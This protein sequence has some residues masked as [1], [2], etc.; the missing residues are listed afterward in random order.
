MAPVSSFGLIAFRIKN[1]TF[2]QIDKL[3]TDNK[4]LTGL[5]SQE[6]QFLLIQRKD[7]IGY[8][9]L[10]RGKYSQDDLV[11]IKAQ[12]AGMTETERQRILDLPFEK[13]W[14]EMWGSCSSN[15]KQYTSEF[16]ASKRKIQGLRDS[17]VLRTL[18]EEAG[19]AVYKTPEWGFPKG[20]R[21]QREDNLT[22][23][24]REFNEETGLRPYHYVVLENMDPIRETFF[25]NNHVH[26]THVY[27]MAMCSS[28]LEVSMKRF[29]THMIR[30]VG[31]IQWASLEEALALIRPDN[32][33]K[34]GILLR[35]STILRNYC[36]LQM[37]VFG[38][39][40]SG[41]A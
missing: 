3:V 34:R 29:D 32:V 31:D 21:N 13:V 11:Y 23:A 40:I 41:S 1:N 36:P 17:G 7:S 2:K 8:V 12:I 26:Y 28:D 37:G 10:V 4:S 20:R 22:C 24:M 38:T 27:Y 18:V 9:E 6:I 15:S 33:E 35:A 30:E 25:G 19:P 16:E 5:E 14:N 39:D